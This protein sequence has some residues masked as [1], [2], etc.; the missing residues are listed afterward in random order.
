MFN[1]PETAPWG[2]V[3]V[4]AVL[5]V[6]FTGLALLARSLWPQNS[7]DRKELWQEWQRGRA[8]RRGDGQGSDG[9]GIEP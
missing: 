8:N 1:L 3:L 2:A 9:E 6:I 4:V 7:R 5:V